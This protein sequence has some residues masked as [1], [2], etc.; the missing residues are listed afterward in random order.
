[1]RHR[2]AVFDDPYCYKGTFVLKNRADLRDQRRLKA[3]ELEM[4]SLRAEEP[5]PKGRFGHNRV[6]ERSL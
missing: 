4:S 3:F 1:M 2:Y 6:L 5:L